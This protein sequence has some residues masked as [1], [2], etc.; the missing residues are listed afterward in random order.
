MCAAPRF[1]WIYIYLSCT[2]H[3]LYRINFIYTH[4]WCVKL[5][6]YSS[7]R[8]K[9]LVSVCVH[10]TYSVY[11]KLNDDKIWEQIRLKLY[12]C[13]KVDPIFFVYVNDIRILL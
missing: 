2:L 5:Y 3:A 8:A 7:W 12:M 11:I 10:L 4:T 13:S 9:Y 1:G 6:A